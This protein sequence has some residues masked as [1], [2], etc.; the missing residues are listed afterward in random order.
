MNLEHHGGR[1]AVNV[2][3]LPAQWPVS[4]VTQVVRQRTEFC[5]GF[6]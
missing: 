6:I 2:Y 3:N 4:V 1:V 5:L